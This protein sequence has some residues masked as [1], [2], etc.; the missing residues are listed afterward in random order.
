MKRRISNVRRKSTYEKQTSIQGRIRDGLSQLWR[1]DL[2]SLISSKSTNKQQSNSPIT[3]IT[4][5][6]AIVC[7]FHLERNMRWAGLE[8]SSRHYCWTDMKNR[9]SASVSEAVAF[10]LRNSLATYVQDNVFTLTD[11]SPNKILQLFQQF[12]TLDPSNRCLFIFNGH[13]TPEPVTEDSLILPPDE[14]FDKSELPISTLVNSLPIP[15]CFIFDADFS[16]GLFKT[17]SEAANGRDQIAFFSCGPNECLPHRIGLPS[18]LFTSCLLTPAYISM[19]WGSRQFYAF[20]SGGLHQFQLNQ[21]SDENRVHPHLLLFS[22]EIERLLQCLV[23]AMAYSSLTPNNL[24][25]LF[26]RDQKVGKLYVNFCVAQR[27]GSEIGFTPMSYPEIP[28]FSRHHLWDFFD[29]Y[30]DTV[31]FRLTEIESS[32]SIGQQQISEDMTF[33]LS[34]ALTTIE[35]S[36]EMNFLEA[37]VPEISLLPLI[38]LDTNLI[39]RSIISFTKFID[40]GVK[41]LRTS[42]SS[43]YKDFRKEDFLNQKNVSCKRSNMS[44]NKIKKPVTE[45]PYGKKGPAVTTAVQF[46]RKNLGDVNTQS[47]KNYE[48]TL[49]KT[50]QATTARRTEQKKNEMHKIDFDEVSNYLSLKIHDKEQKI[51]IY[52]NKLKDA[53]RDLEELVERLQAEHQQLKES[54][55]LEL[56]QLKNTI[57]SNKQRLASLSSIATLESQFKNEINEAEQ[58]LNKEKAEQNQQL[59]NTLTEYYLLDVKHQAELQEAVEQEKTKYR[60]MAYGNIEKTVIKMMKDIDSEIKKYSTM[61]TNS[62]SVIGDNSKLINLNKQLKMERNLLRHQHDELTEKIT[63]NNERIKNLTEELKEKDEFLTSLVASQKE[64]SEV[65]DQGT[66][67]EETERPE[68]TVDDASSNREVMLNNFF[69]KSVNI[70]CDSVVKILIVMDPQHKD[71][72]NS[73]HQLFES[74]EGKK[75]EIRFLLSKLG[76]LTFDVNEQ[77]KLSTIGTIE[78]EGADQEVSKKKIIEPLKKAIL[79][80][81]APIPTDEFPDLIA[82]QFFQ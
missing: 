6:A 40:T 14:G 38:L 24:F 76:N 82:T 49:L 54:Q 78:I 39:E 4:V 62:K 23:K 52:Q 50:Q 80:F 66:P 55:E 67:T 45:I 17:F 69:E 72:Y 37:E 44:R 9:D 43:F 18:D 73:F 48:Q 65:I 31:L 60:E 22:Y 33:F 1:F 36:L 61:V 35:N 12:Q 47:I 10:Q 26:Y 11:P 30:L 70:L 64:E 42:S 41:A 27:I 51:Q 13:G 34:N 77:M 21:F 79:N 28:D 74:F 29:L 46:E 59:S 75:K 8:L 63:K 7:L 58:M 2:K 71:D 16:G 81:A 3:D 25:D 56:K 68:Q 32:K 53:Q 15:G 19:L 57:K 5:S 20:D